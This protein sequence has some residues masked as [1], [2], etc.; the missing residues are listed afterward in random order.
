MISIIAEPVSCWTSCST[1][2]TW[3]CTVT[4]SA[5]VGSSAISSFGSLAIAMAIIARWRIPPENSCGYCD[6]R[7]FGSGTPTRLSRS[8]GPSPG[9]LLRR[10][11]AVQAGSPRRSDRR[12]EDRVQGRHRI[13]EDHRDV[14]AADRCASRP[15]T[16]EGRRCRRTSTE[17]VMS[18]FLGCSCINAS[19]VTDLPEPGL[20]HHG[21][22]LSRADVEAHVGH[23][24]HD[25]VGRAER[26][27][28]VVDLQQRGRLTS[29]LARSSNEG[30][31]RHAGRL[32]G[33]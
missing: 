2:M 11:R 14:L 17:P 4:S 3:A 28:Q 12:R 27:V 25:T 33:S 16:C 5:V 26:D 9:T 29:A 6:A 22:H 7:A 10:V 24:V 18:V 32:R 13:L 30:R 31:A 19:A 20:A 21:E 15:R 8:T 23:R 1:S